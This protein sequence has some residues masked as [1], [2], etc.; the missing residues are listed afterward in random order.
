MP[1]IDKET[2]QQ[3]TDRADIV[4]VVSDYVNLVRRGANYMGLCPFHNERTPSFSVNKRKNFCF[5]FSCKQGGSPVNFIMKKEGLSYHE[6]L[7]HLARKY[8]I[9]VRQRELTD[10]EKKLQSERESMFIANEW[11]MKQMKHNLLETEEGQQIGLSYFYTQRGITREALD[12]FQLGYSLD[13]GNALTKEAVKMGFDIEILKKVG[14]VGTSQDGRNYDKYRGRVIFPIINTAGKVIGF[15]GR[16]L[17]NDRAKYINSPESEIYKKSNELYGIFQARAAIG[18]EDKCFLVEGYFDVIGMWQ[19]GMKNVVASSG[20]ALT[21]GQIALIHRFTDNI[22]L[23]YDGDKA[24]IKAA[25]RGV[26]MLLHHKMK[27]KVLLLPDGDDP[28]SFARKNTPEEFRKFVNENETDVITFKARVLVDDM[29]TDPQRRID[30]VR[31]MVTTLAHISDPIAR[32]VYIQECSSMM[33]IPEETILKSVVKKRNELVATWKR[34]RTRKSLSAFAPDSSRPSNNASQVNK[35]KIDSIERPIQENSRGEIPDE[36]F[37][38]GITN[39]SQPQYY[40]EKK[41]SSLSK[42]SPLFELEK[43]L[44]LYCVKYGFIP[45]CIIENKGENHDIELQSGEDISTEQEYWNIAEFIKLDLKKDNIEFSIPVFSKLMEIILDLK[46]S[47][48]SARK[49]KIDEIEV[50]LIKMQKEGFKEIAS[51]DL[52]LDDIKK[53]EKILESNLKSFKTKELWDF[54][55]N[56]VVKMLSSHEDDEIREIVTELAVERHQLSNIYYRDNNVVE[57]EEDRLFLLVPR[58]LNELKSEI[59]NE[60]VKQ[61]FQQLS[62][63]GADGDIDLE[64]KLQAE[65]NEK[66]LLRAGMAKGLGERILSPLSIRKTF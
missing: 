16:T 58:A 28:D 7:L 15:G 1:L 49:R 46:E 21:D 44:I 52:L 47:Y 22:T 57:T 25:L 54:D 61:L 34:E 48:I 38:A 3:I 11:A 6:A 64:I 27:V 19:S 31:D 23:I 4:E 63:A 8:G 40:V 18:K 30:A 37:F 14:L 66:I 62:K 10:E 50:H 41:S 45:F 5:C 56:Y 24:G 55:K 60:Q 65:I 17:K 13:N 12:A 42:L 36:A 29:V 43:K 32:D 39:N 33:N 9:E 35:S 20:T 2:V 51:K 59:L 53:E 26:D